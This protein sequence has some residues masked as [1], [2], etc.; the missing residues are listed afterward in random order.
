VSSALEGGGWSASRPGRFTPRKDPLPII[1]EAGWAQGPVWTCAKNRTHTGIRSPDRPASSQ[2]LYRLSYRARL[3][4][5]VQLFLC[6]WNYWCISYDIHII[7]TVPTEWITCQ[8]KGG[9]G[10][11][12]FSF[13][14]LTDKCECISDS[15]YNDT[16]FIFFPV[17]SNKC[18]HSPI[19]PS[20]YFSL[21][22]K[23]ITVNQYSRALTLSGRKV[24]C[25]I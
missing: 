9:V 25:C 23:P 13:V 7:S 6:D 22:K 18:S 12:H 2:S 3:K 11:S 4:R 5:K 14:R 19:D 8:G 24:D 15:F 20:S 10:D 16:G 17:S 1:Q 21:V